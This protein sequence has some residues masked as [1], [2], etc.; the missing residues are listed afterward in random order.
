M[1]ALNPRIEKVDGSALV[2]RD[3]QSGVLKK[4]DQGDDRCYVFLARKC[5]C[6]TLYARGLC[7]FLPYG[8]CPYRCSPQWSGRSSASSAALGAVSG[9]S[10][11]TGG[12]VN[13]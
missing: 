12:K 9:T 5:P 3:P 2:P 8:K 4:D 1:L 13:P 6:R 11:P 10:I 7:T